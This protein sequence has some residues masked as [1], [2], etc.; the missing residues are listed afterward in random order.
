LGSVNAA[1]N[2]GC[3]LVLPLVGWLSDRIGRKKVL[4]LGII[5]VVVASILQATS[6]TLAQFIVSRLVVGASGMLVVQPAPMLIAE[7]AYPTHR[8]KYTCVEQP[9]RLIIN[10]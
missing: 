4:F 7:L 10:D 1:Q 2:I 5:G 3:V 6:T 9:Q 8:A